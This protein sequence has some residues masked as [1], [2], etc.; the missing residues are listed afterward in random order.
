MLPNEIGVVCF[1]RRLFFSINERKPPGVRER[2][3][4]CSPW[5]AL[6]GAVL[7]VFPRLLNNDSLH[8]SKRR[9]VHWYMISPRR[10]SPMARSIRQASQSTGVLAGCLLVAEVDGESDRLT[11]MS[12]H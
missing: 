2:S 12:E 5:S 1:A 6:H 8:H 7:E 4:A 11:V 3:L 10:S 9:M